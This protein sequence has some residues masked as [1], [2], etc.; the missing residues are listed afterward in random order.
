MSSLRRLG[1]HAPSSPPAPTGAASFSL[2][3]PAL[4]TVAVWIGL[5]TVSWDRFL[6]VQVGSFNVKTP[7]IAFGLALALG[8]VEGTRHPVRRGAKPTRIPLLL[9]ATVGCFAAVGL[10]ADD[11]RVAELQTVTV[12]LGALAPFLAVY[13]DLRR[14]GRVD[15]ALTWFIRGGAVASVFGLY[16]L[17]AW[18]A[19]LPQIVPYD[20]E[21]GG[22]GRIS[23][24]SYEAGYFGYFLVLVLAALFA[25]GQL[26]GR[27]VGIPVILFFTAVLVLANSRATFITVPLAA[28]LVL[29]RWPRRSVRARLWPVGAILLWL[30]AV[31]IVAAPGLFTSVTSRAGTLFDPDESTSNAPRLETIALVWRVVRDHPLFGIGPGNLL[32]HLGAY[33][34]TPPPGATA[35]SFVANDVWL[36]AGLD[37]GIVL[38]ALEVALVVL[39]VATLYRR[40]HPV[41]RTLI[42]GW[43]GFFLPA[44]FITSYFW[45]MKVWV[46]VALAC[47]IAAEAA[48]TRARREPA[49]A[50]TVEPRL[51]V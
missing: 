48:P 30:L 13:L 36:Q 49:H 27:P 43:L 12:V 46:F 51:D 47:A 14:H 24:F 6:Q 11:I 42:G 26:R 35:N 5:F 50:D 21:S 41:A 8:L 15:A 33:G 40:R 10:A 20:A 31:L 4:S 17:A 29:M 18:Y 23:S 1:A 39:I 32:G 38:L 3:G 16:Q 9:V 25:R 28:L 44:S 19:G 45:D 37:G 2:R 7:T 22:L 34:Q